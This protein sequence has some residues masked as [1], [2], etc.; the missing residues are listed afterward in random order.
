MT[1]SRVRLTPLVAC[2]LIVSCGSES[3]PPLV[4]VRAQANAFGNAE[5]S[6]PVNVGAPVNSAASESNAAMSPDELSLYFTSDRPGGHGALDIWV[7]RRACIDCPWGTPLPLKV[8]VNSPSGEAGPRLSIDGHLLFF[9]SDRPGG[10]GAFDIYVSR[11]NNTNDDFA[12][13]DPVAL[14]TDVNTPVLE[15]AAVYLQSAE[16]GSGNL[17]FNRGP[18]GGQDIY[19]APV[20]RDGETRGPAVYVSELSDPAGI[21]Q[22]V[23]LR[24]DAREVFIASTR[25]GGLGGFDLWTSTRRSTHDA[26]SAPVNLGAPMNTTVNDQQPSLTSDSRTLL[27]ASNRPGGLGGN[28]LWISTRTP[29]GH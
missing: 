23:T 15:Q 17:Y 7:S 20:T 4:G 18:V 3:D 27:F 26:W 6:A 19:Y 11:R 8:P 13:G 28:D 1:V 12:W 10:Q 9:Q 21:D 16:D 25:A 5:W 14:G 22:H 2:A 29:S 24:K